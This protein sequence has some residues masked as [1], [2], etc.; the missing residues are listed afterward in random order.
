MSN[1]QYFCY[2]INSKFGHSSIL[3]NEAVVNTLFYR[4]NEENTKLKKAHEDKAKILVLGKSQFVPSVCKDMCFK[5]Y[6]VVIYTQYI[7]IGLFMIWPFRIV[8]IESS[9]SY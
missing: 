7:M 8:E 5:A 4:A 1:T 3:G 6:G 9:T 2:L